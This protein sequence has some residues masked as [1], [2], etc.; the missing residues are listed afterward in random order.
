MLKPNSTLPEN[1]IIRERFL[2]GG[3]MNRTAVVFSLALALSCAGVAQ[4]GQSQHKKLADSRTNSADTSTITVNGV[5]DI[6]AAKAFGSKEPTLVIELFS[7]F[8]CPMCRELYETTLKRLMENYVTGVNPCKV[9]IVHRDFTWPYHAYARVAANYSRAAAH[10]GKCQEVEEALFAN[11][12]KWE[13]SGDV[14]GTVASVL[15]PAE[16]KTVE[17]LVESKAL[18]PLIERDQQLGL[19]L[20]VRGTPTLVV[21]GRDG[22]VYP[23]I[24]IVS[25]DALKGFID[26]LLRQS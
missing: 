24:G 14:K 3:S 13:S 8:Q 17:R 1:A 22:Q 9:Y 12:Q 7:D 25:Y 2:F 16:M 18:E 21:H 26:R 4:T 23:V 5:A 11:Q 6:D 20:P 10:I 15:S 19:A